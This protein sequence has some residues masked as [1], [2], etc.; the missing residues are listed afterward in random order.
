LDIAV[1][2][3]GATC[4]QFSSFVRVPLPVKA[5]APE[6]TLGVVSRMLTLAV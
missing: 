1:A 4:A 3:T 5:V 6:G 2:V